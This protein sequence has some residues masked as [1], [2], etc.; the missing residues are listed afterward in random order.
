MIGGLTI[1]GDP[2]PGGLGPR[3]AGAF[4]PDPGVGTVA[5]RSAR[6]PKARASLGFA[7]PFV[8]ISSEETF[9]PGTLVVRVDRERIASLDP[10]SLRLVRWDSRQARLFV[11]ERSGPG[12]GG[13]YA[14]G[15]VAVPGR[16]GVIGR[17][18][19]PAAI[20]VVG[21][22]AAARELVPGLGAK[23][24]AS[25]HRRI[26]ELVPPGENGDEEG[27]R[28]RCLGLTDPFA[29]PEF[30]LA[31]LP[32]ADAW[33]SIGTPGEAPDEPASVI[34]PVLS[35]ALDPGDP[36][37]LYVGSAGT[38]LWRLDGLD[39]TPGWTRLTDRDGPLD[40]LAVA[41]ASADARM[42]YA[43]DG[44]G[45]V[46][47]SQDGG[48]TW[49]SA[50]VQAFRGVN[51]L[52]IHPGEARRIYLA[53]ESPDGDTDR[54]QGGLWVSADAGESWTQL[55]AGEVTD[56]AIDPSDPS[57][58]YAA[59][60]GQGLLRSDDGGVTWLSAHPFVSTEA[61][62][63]SEIAVAIGA[64]QHSEP[65]T[66]VVRL[67]QEIL[68][69]RHGGRRPQQP[70][71]GGWVSKGWQ[72]GEA[73]ETGR[74]LV[75]ADPNDGDVILAVGSELVR[76]A[77]ASLR[78]GGVWE[79]LA[80]GA[81]ARCLLHDP[82]HAGV[83]FRGGDRGLARSTDGGA[84]WSAVHER[85]VP[86]RIECAAVGPE[87]ILADLGPGGLVATTRSAHGV[88]SSLGAEGEH[89]WRE[90]VA[91]PG[92]PGIFYLM[93]ETLG[94]VRRDSDG[95]IARDQDWAAF[96]PVSAA[97]GAGPGGVLLAGTTDRILRLTDQ[98][99]AEIHN[100]DA[101]DEGWAARPIAALAFAPNSSHEAYAITEGGE[102]FHEPDVGRDVWGAW[103]RTGAWDVEDVRGLAVNP[104]D[105]RR[106]YAIAGSE[107][108]RSPDRGESWTPIRGS[109]RAALPEV[110][111]TG[112][113]AHPDD[114]EVL[115]VGCDHAIFFTADEGASWRP[116]DEGLPRSP[117]VQ[118]GWWGAELVAVT[119]GQGV[120]KRRLPR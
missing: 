27:L 99:A 25:L 13:A 91:N 80:K 55:V 96:R 103:T 51:R 110:A 95:S 23:E 73:P 14:S 87:M 58:L 1:A 66:V 2:G 20:L 85:S 109:G 33:R 68:L 24:R 11:V 12:G 28:E 117:V 113:L 76:T 4:I 7:G 82:N 15:R 86:V 119:R 56:A 70:G 46:L 114:P 75:A 65:R 40:V 16:Y 120:W 77:T 48:A 34:G 115:V 94:R 100:W 107:I 37:R 93:G 81:D 67:G 90:I 3:A 102:V 38:G 92:R 5:V 22:L 31:P 83:V 79:S 32:D 50:G 69:S 104:L 118:I 57:V 53:T 17:S 30:D 49:Q 101:P 84:S 47:R 26:C 71:G 105:E 19:D 98:D 72:G 78:A 44:V 54:G 63:G 18:S 42:L 62:G 89:R 88:W 61:H 35:M 59:L 21:A 116:C 45:R 36:G 112:I 41:V 8:E 106:I 108:G 74:G 29:L 64:R 6:A 60:R 9:I 39:G 52:L 97:A 43:T 111:L 10:F